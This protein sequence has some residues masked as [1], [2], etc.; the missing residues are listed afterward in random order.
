MWRSGNWWRAMAGAACCHG[1]VQCRA[2]PHE[3]PAVSPVFRWRDAELD[4]LVCQILG[5]TPDVMALAAR[6]QRKAFRRWI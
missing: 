3:K 6:W 4:H 2:L 1:N 5:S